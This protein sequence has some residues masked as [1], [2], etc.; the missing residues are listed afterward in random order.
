MKINSNWFKWYAFAWMIFSLFFLMS[1]LWLWGYSDDAK[2]A[3]ITSDIN[4]LQSAISIRQA[5]W[6]TLSSLI[7]STDNNIL[8][9][10]YVGG[11]KANTSDR[12]YIVGNVNYSMIGIKKNDFI[13]PNKKEY[14]VGYTNTWRWRYEIAGVLRNGLKLEAIVKGTYLWRQKEECEIDSIKENTVI[15]NWRCTNMFSREDI[16]EIEGVYF[17][18]KKVWR[19]WITITLDGIPNLT[20]KYISLA[21]EEWES[22]ISDYIDNKKSVVDWWTVYLPYCTEEWC[23][24][25]TNSKKLKLIKYTVW[26]KIVTK[27]E[28]IITKIN[29]TKLKQV[30]NKIKKID[31]NE[32]KYSKYKTLLEYIKIRIEVEIEDRNK[33]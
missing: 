24:L 16:V 26:S 29:L 32:K 21:K 8:T 31:L 27:L 7:L 33:K 4:N 23:E 10:L 30:L 3:K 14:I 12:S 6:N 9:G 15:L 20:S 13:S 19:D 11:K 22:L 28:R 1:F 5:Q 17:I 2:N 25:E 18:A